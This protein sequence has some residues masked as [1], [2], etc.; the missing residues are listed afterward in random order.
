[1]FNN[2]LPFLYKKYNEIFIDYYY[3]FLLQNNLLLS[4][5]KLQ[6]GNGE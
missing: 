2:I 5:R 6:L 3:N 4:K 1:M